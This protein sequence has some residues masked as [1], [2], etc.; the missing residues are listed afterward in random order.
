MEAIYRIP[1]ETCEYSKAGETV[2]NFFKRMKFFYNDAARKILE[3]AGNS[4]Y[5]ERKQHLYRKS[6]QTKARWLKENKM[7]QE[8]FKH[9]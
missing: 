5:M 2:K 8:P 9:Y 3:E 4:I 1:T 7:F 6:K